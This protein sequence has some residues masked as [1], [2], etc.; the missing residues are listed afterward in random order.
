MI[1]VTE[2]TEGETNPASAPIGDRPDNLPLLIPTLAVEAIGTPDHQ[3][4]DDV[5]RFRPIRKQHSV[6]CM[7][8][9]AMV[10]FVQG[11]LDGKGGD[12]G[13]LQSVRNKFLRKSRQRKHCF[14]FFKSNQLYLIKWQTRQQKRLF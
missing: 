3:D 7:T 5:V 11:G 1:A 6:G 4:D 14:P 2:T 13:R 10:C 9:P 12:S 8:D